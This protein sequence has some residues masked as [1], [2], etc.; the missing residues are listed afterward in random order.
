MEGFVQRFILMGIIYLM[1]ASILGIIM[2]LDPAAVNLRF[3][4]VHLNLLGWMSMLIFGV[5]YHILPRFSGKPLHSNRLGEIQFWLANIG[6]IGLALIATVEQ[7][8]PGDTLY[9]IYLTSGVLALL[10]ILMF[11][12]NMIMTLFVDKPPA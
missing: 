4:H 2:I 3:A 8:S 7:V 12:Y 9:G 1:I 11:G 5:G 6:L 10:S